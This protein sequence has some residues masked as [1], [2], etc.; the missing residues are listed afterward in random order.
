MPPKEKKRE[1]YKTYK[2]STNQNKA[3]HS[4]ELGTIVLFNLVLDYVKDHR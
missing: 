2:K 4:L 3:L 1:D